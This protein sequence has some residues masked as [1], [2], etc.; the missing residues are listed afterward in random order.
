[1]RARIQRDIFQSAAE[2]GITPYANVGGGH[3]HMGINSGFEG[4]P[5]LFRNFVADYANH[6]EFNFGVMDNDHDN[7]PVIQELNSKQRR[8]FK[9]LLADFDAGYIP[10]IAEFAERMEY[11]VYYKTN[12]FWA[13]AYKYHALNVHRAFSED[14]RPSERTV[15]M[16]AHRAQQSAQEFVDLAKMYQARLDFL[17]RQE[18]KVI[19]FQDVVPIARQ[20]IINAYATYL[21]ECGLDYEKYRP[22]LDEALQSYDQTRSKPTKLKSVCNALLLS[23]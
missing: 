21:Q 9:Q 16:R 7:G 1:M 6:S 4:N 23:A 15:E 18:N 2:V 10:T 20:S 8:Q 11:E 3:I 19:P 13:P 12:R 17:E 22:Y 14:F 5:T